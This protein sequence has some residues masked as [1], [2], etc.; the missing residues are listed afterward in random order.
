MHKI[1]P[2]PLLTCEMCRTKRGSV[3]GQTRF[4]LCGRH[5]SVIVAITGPEEFLAALTQ[6]GS[7]VDYFPEL[8]PLPFVQCLKKKKFFFHQSW[9]CFLL[10]LSLFLSSVWKKEAATILSYLLSSAALSPLQKEQEKIFLI[11]FYL[12]F[13]HLFQL[14]RSTLA[15]M[16]ALN[17]AM[18]RR[19]FSS[20]HLSDKRDAP[21][22]FEC[23]ALHWGT[24]FKTNE[25]FIIVPVSSSTQKQ[26]PF[27]LKSH[28]R[29]N[30]EN[31][32]HKILSHDR[33]T[34]SVIAHIRVL[35]N[36]RSAILLISIYIKWHANKYWNQF[37]LPVVL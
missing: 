17:S 27:K 33:V 10:T 6:R 12:L 9:W 5:S 4:P 21:P 2:R 24:L 19:F 32:V 13:A 36:A 25:P 31:C 14:A 11:Y 3:C 22:V 7:L 37:S 34:K 23:R 16:R 20:E 35:S 18:K 29:W 15:P 26:Y 30:F 1:A 8:L 28:I